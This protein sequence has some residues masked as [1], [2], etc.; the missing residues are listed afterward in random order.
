MGLETGTTI[1]ALNAAWPLGTDVRSQGDDHIRLV[2]AV[3]KNDVASRALTTAQTFAGGLKIR[4][5]EIGVAS[6]VHITNATG[7]LIHDVPATFAHRFRIAGADAGL[8]EDAA[9][10]PSSVTLMTR[11]KADARYLQLSGA[12]ALTGTLTTKPGSTSHWILD[13]TGAAANQFDIN[14]TGAANATLQAIRFGRSSP[15]GNLSLVLHDPGTATARMQLDSAGTGKITTGVGQFGNIFIGAGPDGTAAVQHISATTG[16]SLVL[17]SGLDTGPLMLFRN[18]ANVTVAQLEV[19]GT[20]SPNATTIITREK[21]DLRYA[22]KVLLLEALQALADSAPVAELRD[23][24][25]AALT[26]PVEP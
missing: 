11:A 4:D 3:V 9:T 25:I 10:A 2:K 17:R 13:N 23:A 14:T 15:V 12:A 18:A 7:S 8:V 5:V 19:A 20:A 21:G 24:M 22:P 26:A 16:L 6:A 1:A